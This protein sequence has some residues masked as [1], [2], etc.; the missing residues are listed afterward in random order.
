MHLYFNLGGGGGRGEEK[1]KKKER[2]REKTI[3]SQPASSELGRAR[4]W[5]WVS[6][7]QVTALIIGLY[8][9][10][11]SPPFWPSEY[12]L[13]KMERSNRAAELRH[14]PG[15]HQS[16]MQVFWIC[17][18]TSP[19]VWVIL[20]SLLFQGGSASKKD[21]SPNIANSWELRDSALVWESRL[22][23]PV[24]SQA[25]QIFKLV[26]IHFSIIPSSPKYWFLQELPLSPARNS[27]QNKEGSPW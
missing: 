26:M 13:Y 12:Y 23:F 21:I 7:I 25:E 8:S 14:P 15:M 2:E 6:C 5:T 11:L 19:S 18:I 27:I 4:T 3:H 16:Q 1:R 20:F 22:K 24:P 9:L 10:S 17:H